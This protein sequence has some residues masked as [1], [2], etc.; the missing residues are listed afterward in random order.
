MTKGFLDDIDMDPALRTVNRWHD[1]LG[2]A[3]REQ[4]RRVR[5]KNLGIIHEDL[6]ALRDKLMQTGELSKPS[7]SRNTPEG[8]GQLLGDILVAGL[9]PVFR[10]LQN[11]ADRMQQGRNN[12]CVAFALAAHQRD[13]GRYPPDLSSLAPKYLVKLPFDIF[14]NRP[15]LYRPRADGYLLYSVGVNGRDDGGRAFYEDPTC[16]DLAVRMPLPK[17]P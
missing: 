7:R 11:A 10:E 17:I 6:S 4:N 5:E 15:L 16:D 2:R 9:V 1:R 13:H 3:M 14:S 8:R 12:L